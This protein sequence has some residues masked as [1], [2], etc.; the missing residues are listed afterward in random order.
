MRANKSS[1]DIAHPR[2]SFSQSNSAIDLWRQNVGFMLRKQQRPREP[3]GP[4]ASQQRTTRLLKG[5]A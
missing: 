2:S 1:R 5:E 3:R 4:I